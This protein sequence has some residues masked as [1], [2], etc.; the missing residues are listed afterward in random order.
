MV[1]SKKF[2]LKLLEEITRFRGYRAPRTSALCGSPIESCSRPLYSSTVRDKK[3]C[4]VWISEEAVSID[5]AVRAHAMPWS[6]ESWSSVHCHGDAMTRRG[7]RKMRR[8]DQFMT[9]NCGALRR[10]RSVPLGMPRRPK[11]VALLTRR[12]PACLAHFS[13]LPLQG[14]R[15]VRNYYRQSP[16]PTLGP[17]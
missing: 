14:F 9:G 17:S 7:I 3:K 4:F 11:Q 16:P 5:G 13:K 8:K 15:E 12:A 10:Y 2:A 1:K 6:Q